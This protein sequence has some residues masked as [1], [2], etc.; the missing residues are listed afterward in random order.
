MTKSTENSRHQVRAKTSHSQP[1]W[2]AVFF[3]IASVI[4]L[5]PEAVFNARLVA[6]AGSP[7]STPENMHL[8]E[9]FGRS[10][11]G[12]GFSLLIADALL[13][14][15]IAKSRL[16]ALLS[17]VVITLIVWPLVFFGQK[18]LVDKLLIDQSSPSQ[19][20]EAFFSSL[21]KSSLAS[22]VINIEGLSYNVNDS[23]NPSDMTF[24]TMLGGLAYANSDF[25]TSLESQKTKILDSYI[26]SKANENFEEHYLRYKKVRDSVQNSWKTYQKKVS[27]YNSLISSSQQRSDKAWES[28]ES[29]IAKGYHDYRNAELN[30]LARAEA[31]AQVIA[32]PIYDYWGDY[33][34]CDKRY[35]NNAE[36]HNSCIRNVDKRYARLL[37]KSSISYVPMTY[38]A[39]VRERE[40]GK[41][42]ILETA[43]TLGTS[44]LVAGLEVLA[45]ES[46]EIEK[47]YIRVKNVNF[48]TTK[49]FTLMTDDFKKETGYET[50]ISNVREFRAHPY[51][52]E[53]V[54]QD[55]KAKQG[56]EL[57]PSWRIDQ[58]SSFKEAVQKK[59]R[60][61]A[62]ASWQK[63]AR[64]NGYD[65]APNLSWS[66]FQESA[67]IQKKIRTQMGDNY[68]VKPVLATWNNKEFYDY[69]IKPNVIREREYWL[70][71][72]HA[73]QVQFADGG[74]LE[75]EGKKAL[76]SILVPPIS[77]A[78]S[79]FLVLLTVLKLPF[80]F[81][82]L[83]NYDKHMHSSLK[84]KAMS[85]LLSLCFIT[86]IFYLPI[87]FLS[88]KFTQ[89][90]S[91]LHQ[92]INTENGHFSKAEA[93]AIQ[94]VLNT[95]PIIQPIGMF[96]DRK[97]SI[98]TQFEDKLKDALEDF[99]NRYYTLIAAKWSGNP[100]RIPYIL[101][102]NG[103]ILY[104]FT[105]TTNVENASVR[106][107]NIAPVY[108]KNASDT[109][110]I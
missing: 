45:G 65:I 82:V 67:M 3:F 48:Y 8:I 73:S 53:K 30:Y 12:V 71:Y 24:L 34:S 78:I 108:Q 59:V 11:S 22:D 4:Y 7:N 35:H 106:I 15:R 2:L 29:I 102:E 16:K 90:N 70:N 83:L 39:E 52:A 33:S 86:V 88:S 61:E 91:S 28:V 18:L 38:F 85:V 94:W 89:Q 43:L 54:R 105:I 56:I 96:I 81:F 63:N 5:F 58:I 68:Y 6:L 14:G 36:R 72:I 41:T 92:L 26:T 79:L 32:Q 31:R 84:R 40:K 20:Q 97:T 95:Q 104:P 69:I 37:E 49:V 42:S 13:K 80:K 107:M 21:L 99:D 55:I 19:R 76:R 51:T 74:T 46:G 17:L 77:M 62:D 27:S 47:H 109:R 98:S 64:M 100:P 101:D 10:V 110:S 75:Q 9:L 44:A 93:L 1:K 50:D 23:E 57:P 25:L 66:N 103:S 87:Q 60:H